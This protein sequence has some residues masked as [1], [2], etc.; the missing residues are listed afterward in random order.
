MRGAGESGPGGT[1]DRRSSGCGYEV[2][3]T[4]YRRFLVDYAAKLAAREAIGAAIVARRLRESE[5]A[6]E[7]FDI[8]GLAILDDPRALLETAQNKLWLAGQAHREGDTA[9]NR[10]LLV[11]AR[12]LLERLLRME[13][14][15]R[16]HAWAWRELAR[17]RRWLGEPVATVDEAYA[18]A[19]ELAPDETKFSKEWDRTG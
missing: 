10:T 11:D 5:M 2:G 12:V 6:A 18:K 16:R 19:V 13:A 8:A 1:G 3:S 7:L 9:R 4:R 14:P 17:A 15:R